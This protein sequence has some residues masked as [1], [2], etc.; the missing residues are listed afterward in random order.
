VAVAQPERPVHAGLVRRQPHRRRDRVGRAGDEA[1]GV[2][3]RADV[4]RGDAVAGICLQQRDGCLD[5]LGR[6]VQR[7]LVGVGAG[8][9]VEQP[10]QGVGQL[11]R[12]GGHVRG[13]RLA[14]L[15]T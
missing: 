13:A 4:H 14:G 15:W 3:E 1:E 8:Y 2:P 11:V 5:E 9:G 6:V 7:R 10:A 12:C